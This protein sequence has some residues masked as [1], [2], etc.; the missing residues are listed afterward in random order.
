MTYSHSEAKTE[1]A[2]CVD[3]SKEAVESLQ[4]LDNV[5]KG[6]FRRGRKEVKGSKEEQVRWEKRLGQRLG[7]EFEIQSGTLLRSLLIKTFKVSDFH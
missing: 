1:G 5:E 6:L 4:K 2:V 3:Q 7:S